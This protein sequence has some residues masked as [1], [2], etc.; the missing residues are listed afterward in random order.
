MRNDNWLNGNDTELNLKQ[1]MGWAV[2]KLRGRSQHAARDASVLLAHVLGAPSHYPF[3]HPRECL[4]EPQKQQY[5]A[6]ILNRL[7][8][9]PVAYLRGYQ[10]FMGLR[11]YV[12]RR[13]LV[14]RP[15]TELL[16]ERLLL[17]LDHCP[18]PVL[19]CDVGCGSGAIGLSVAKLGGHKAVLADISQDALDVAKQNAESLGVSSSVSFLQ[20]DLLAPLREAGYRGC[21]DAVVSNPPYISSG[22]MPFLPDEVKCE[23]P[24]ALDGG[25]RGLDF[26]SRLAAGSRDL[27]K[28]RGMLFMEIGAGQGKAVTELLGDYGWRDVHIFPDY[29]G[30]DRVAFARLGGQQ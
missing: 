13:V 16:V 19:V 24:H 29:A 22:D 3:V 28:P 2:Q 30:L 26:I 4:T 23:P 12:D 27:L 18:P 17:A 7:V 6:L 21:F 20:G 25:A 14:P 11:F 9:V 1:A 5:E 10:E 15:E 8:G